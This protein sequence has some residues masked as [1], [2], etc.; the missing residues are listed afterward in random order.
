MEHWDLRPEPTFGACERCLLWICGLKDAAEIDVFEHMRLGF[1]DSPAAGHLGQLSLRPKNAW[2]LPA[3][4]KTTIVS[5]H[6]LRLV[7]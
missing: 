3:S 6:K 4:A 2:Q 7:T 1:L 5:L